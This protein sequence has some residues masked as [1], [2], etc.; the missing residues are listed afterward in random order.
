MDI[1]KDFKGNYFGVVMEAEARMKCHGTG[2]GSEER[3]TVDVENSRCVTVEGNG[4][5]EL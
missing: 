5:I 2:V 1:L 3:E 4:R